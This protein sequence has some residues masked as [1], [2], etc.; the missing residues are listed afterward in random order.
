M[1]CLYGCL[2]L[3][4][5][6]HEPALGEASK[7][8]SRPFRTSSSWD[9]RG[10]P[11]TSFSCSMR[12]AT[13]WSWACVVIV[14]CFILA[15]SNIR[16]NPVVIY[17]AHPTFSAGSLSHRAPFPDGFNKEHRGGSA[18]DSSVGPRGGTP[19]YCMESRE[20]EY[21]PAGQ[22]RVAPERKNQLPK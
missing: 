21:T 10:L 11:C 4:P 14:C 1:R 2:R 15:K 3:W 8:R 12:E 9:A 19:L 7:S 6:H 22:N 5:L 18:P 13:A 16:L 20:G 17:A